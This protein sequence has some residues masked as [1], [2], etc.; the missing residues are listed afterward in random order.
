MGR[1]WLKIVGSLVLAALTLQLGACA[2]GSAG[3]TLKLEDKYSHGIALMSGVS[4]PTPVRRESTMHAIGG[5][6][7]GRVGLVNITADAAQVHKIVGMLDYQTAQLRTPAGAPLATVPISPGETRVVPFSLDGVPNGRH[8]FTVMTFLSP[9]DH[10]LDD[11]FRDSSQIMFSSAQVVDLTAESSAAGTGPAPKVEA[12]LP[13][14]PTDNATD[15]EL[16]SANARSDAQLYRVSAKPGELVPCTCTV[17]N[18]GASTLEFALSPLLDYQSIAFGRSAVR[19]VEVPAKSQVVIP[20]TVRAPGAPGTH[21]LLVLFTTAP[22][23]TNPLERRTHTTI[24]TALVV[25]GP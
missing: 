2:N 10:S 23:S 9:D 17:T 6:L 11:G 3:G 20:L 5:R 14:S 25:R 24:R 8:T 13:A 21:E 7:L 22:F 18:G 12:N 15:V 19:Y 16:S 1:M 4:G